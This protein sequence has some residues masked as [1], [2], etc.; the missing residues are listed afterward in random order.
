MSTESPHRGTEDLFLNRNE[1]RTV[2]RVILL[3][4]YNERGT[5][6]RVMLLINRLQRKCHVAGGLEVGA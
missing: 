3:L 4:N 5:K 2:L 1:R 6:L